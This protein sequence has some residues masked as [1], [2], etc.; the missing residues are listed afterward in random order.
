MV[1]LTDGFYVDFGPT[2]KGGPR[3]VT[4]PAQWLAEDAPHRGN[5]ATVGF[6]IV[7]PSTA[8]ARHTHARGPRLLRCCRPGRALGPEIERF[9]TPSHDRGPPAARI[10]AKG[11]GAQPARTRLA[12]FADAV[13][14]M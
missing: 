7:I 2:R 3:G 13:E 12:R 11:V 14:E 10:D 4:W 6:A 5:L 1:A 8:A 9:D